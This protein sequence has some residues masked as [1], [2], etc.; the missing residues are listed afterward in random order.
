MSAMASRNL[1]GKHTGGERPYRMVSQQNNN[2]FFFIYN[3]KI[4][5]FEGLKSPFHCTD[6]KM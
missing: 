6:K 2:N 1:S 3:T 5:Y 4:M